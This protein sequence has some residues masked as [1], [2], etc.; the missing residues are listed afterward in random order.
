MIA[1]RD[2][3]Q[4]ALAA[5]AIWG[6]SGMGNWARLAARQALSQDRLLEFDSFG[7][8]TLI[9]VTDIHGQ[10]VPVW[11]REPE[12]NIGVGAAEGQPPHVT[13]A[14]FLKLYGIAPGT[15][16]AYALSYVDFVSL[17][18]SYGR[19][20]GLDRVA[21]V[22][23]AIR[24]D[25]PEALL[26][27]GGDTWHGSY[28]CLRS[29]AQ[30]MVNAMNLLKPDAMTSHWE[31]TLGL[32]RVNEI[33]EGLDFAFLGAN[34]FDAEWDEPAYEPYRIFERGGAKIA[35]IGQAFPYLPIANPNW[36]FP[37][38]SFGV[39]EERMAEMV[40]EVRGKGA[41]LVVVLSHN[42]FDVDR[43]MAGN[44]PGI[45][46]ILTGHTHDALPEPVMVGQT[47]LI[48][49]GSNGKFV[50]RLD[51]DVREGRMM[52]FRHKLIPVFSDAIA[53][54]PEMA[55]LI[56]RERAPYKDEMT[57]VLGT[58]DGLL[59][60]R[61]N[62]NGTWDDLICNALI[63]EREADIALSPGFRWGPSLLPGEPITREDLYN[64][65]AM[66]YP[67]AYR[68][69]M[70]GEMLHTILEDVADNLFNPDPYY[71]QGGDM[72]RVGGMGYRIDV[73][74]PQGSRITG[75]TLLKTGEPIDPARSYVVSGW[76]SV[77]EGTEGPPIWQVVEDYV[78]RQ[79][80]VRVDPNKSVV[81]SGA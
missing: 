76:A 55:A 32:D 62:F 40:R 3:L 80:T 54:D 58:T 27:D 6:A 19:M 66:T 74:R 22:V 37:G 78:K 75:M 57:E 17:A 29:D 39:R 81:V 64:A 71:Q 41:D 18:R 60:R 26:L 56:E 50:T 52:G 23:K 12:V 2:F 15:P 46:V 10:L 25:R 70:T 67:N 28:T 34:I 20:G 63:D 24:A 69:E 38:L 16:E 36:M 51:L 72:V 44:V 68:S 8:V 4:A 9:H 13:G 11:F 30:D 1:R 45:D 79:G 5:S 43:K 77:N 48:A 31:F 65:T 59:Y 53:P 73:T 7:N 35:V 42:G 49:S 14:D 61:G 47:L 21:T 33:V